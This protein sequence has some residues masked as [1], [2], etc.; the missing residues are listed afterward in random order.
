MNIPTIRL[1]RTLEVTM[2]DIVNRLKELDGLDKKSLSEEY[3]EWIEVS[4]S[5]K[6]HPHV[7]YANQINIEQL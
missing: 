3:K 6:D 2:K 5:N 4:D 1:K 7:L